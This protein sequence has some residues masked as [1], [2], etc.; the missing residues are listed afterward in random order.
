MK[1]YKSLSHSVW[2]CKY[3]IVWIP[4]FR[5]KKHYGEVATYLGE[6]FHELA[7]QRESKIVEGHICPDHIHMLIEIPPKHAVAEVVGYI[8]GKSAIAIARTYL[9]K[10]QNF[11]GQNFRA[12]GY[13]VSTVG[14]DEEVIE[15]YIREQEASNQRFA[16]KRLDQLD[17]FKDN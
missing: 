3:H 10:R 1:D 11:T 12:R 9:G 17:M 2:D 15:Q 8:K 16:D 4:K 14:L 5:K 6:I 13:F 7:R